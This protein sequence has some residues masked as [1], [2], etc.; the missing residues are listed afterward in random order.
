MLWTS[1]PSFL[2]TTASP[3]MGCMQLCG[4]QLPRVGDWAA[5]GTAV[6][7][8]EDCA[9]RGEGAILGRKTG[10]LLK[11]AQLKLSR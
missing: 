6:M 8:G 10:A 2:M 7:D 5:V 9:L 4:A 3:C 1:F 11:H